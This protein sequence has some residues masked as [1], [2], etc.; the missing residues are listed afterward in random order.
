MILETDSVFETDSAIS[1]KFRELMHKIL[2]RIYF[3]PIN[4]T[5]YQGKQ[6]KVFLPRKFIIRKLW[7]IFRD[8]SEKDSILIQINTGEILKL[9]IIDKS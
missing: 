8:D 5:S 4:D 6:Q 7:V 2:F 1:T 3:N 9:V